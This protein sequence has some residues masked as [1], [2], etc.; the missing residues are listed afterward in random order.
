[1]LGQVSSASLTDKTSNAGRALSKL[2]AGKGGRA[3]ANVLTPGERRQIAQDAVRARWLK[4]GK[5]KQLVP[6]TEEERVDRSAADQTP[7]SMFQGRLAIGEVELECHVL[8]DGRR[9]LSQ[10]EMV[11]ALSPRGRASGGLR[12]YLDSN[13]LIDG[14]SVAVAATRF[15][16]PGNPTPANGYEATILV[17]ICE[18]YLQARDQ[19]L[20]KANQLPL[21]VQAEIIVRAC[22]KVGIIAL[23]DEATGYQKV[24]A[25]NALRL[26]LQAFIADD[27]QEWARMFPEEFWLELA[28]LEGV[29][30]S[31]RS[32]PLRWGRYVM[33]FV[34]DAVDGDVGKEL[35]KRN[36]DPH[37]LQNH[38]QWLKKFGRE[39]VHDQIQRVVTIMKLCNDMSDFKRKFERVFARGPLQLSFL[40]DDDWDIATARH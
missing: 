6:T 31:P 18:K 29:H 4:A 30:Y 15:R 36:P 17:D 21:A 33:M 32:R 37:F 19:R 7:T 35:R 8:N 39:Q 24:R 25:E 23:I 38:H 20:L 22:A 2:G 26:K 13:P 5:L 28:R 3:R 34:Y 10:R 9:V 12:D 27:L 16:I 14:D 40:D 11:K 1:M